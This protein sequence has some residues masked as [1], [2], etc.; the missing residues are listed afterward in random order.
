MT[1]KNEEALEALECLYG[2]ALEFDNLA[3]LQYEMV[4][5]ALTE[6]NAQETGGVDVEEL[7]NEIS[8]AIKTE[9]TRNDTFANFIADAH[10]IA[11]VRYISQQGH[12]SPNIPQEAI[13]VEELKKPL[14]ES[15][16]HWSVIPADYQVIVDEIGVFF[17]NF[18]WN[19]CVDHLSQQGY[20]SPKIPQDVVDDACEALEIGIKI[21]ADVPPDNYK[22]LYLALEKLNQYRS[23][24]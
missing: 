17:G 13:D 14:Q 6:K 22:P 18:G 9:K 23:K 24:K 20:L 5:E 15:V 16:E 4:L 7:I 10:I 12:L 3:K 2:A 11:T 8:L 21:R 19:M 1:D